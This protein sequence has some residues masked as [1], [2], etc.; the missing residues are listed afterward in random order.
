VFLA[1]HAKGAKTDWEMLGN[2]KGDTP[3]LEFQSGSSLRPWRA[4]RET[5]RGPILSPSTPTHPKC[6][7][8]SA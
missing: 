3:N 2:G 6:A 7:A 4:L 5:I 1:K 8:A